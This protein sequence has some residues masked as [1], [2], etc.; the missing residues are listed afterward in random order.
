MQVFYSVLFWKRLFHLLAIDNW[1]DSNREEMRVLEWFCLSLIFDEDYKY[2][3]S[4]LKEYS[5]IWNDKKWK[6]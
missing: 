1:R 3:S 2:T 5:E 6:D 4:V